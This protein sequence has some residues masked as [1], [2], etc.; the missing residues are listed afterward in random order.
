MPDGRLASPLLAPI[1]PIRMWFQNRVFGGS[2]VLSP[3]PDYHNMLVL[4]SRFQLPGP[5]P[6]SFKTGTTLPSPADP[7][8]LAADTSRPLPFEMA[9]RGEHVVLLLG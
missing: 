4:P 9:F 5:F 1:R 6:P 8:S 3:F 7:S 2:A